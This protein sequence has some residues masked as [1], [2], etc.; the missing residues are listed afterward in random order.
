MT[1]TDNVEYLVMG[2]GNKPSKGRTKPWN[3]T[4]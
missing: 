3:G 1:F 2:V 4:N